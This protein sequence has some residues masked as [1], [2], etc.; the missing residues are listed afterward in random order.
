MKNLGSVIAGTMNW[1]VW[2]KKLS[3]TQMV[4][5]MKAY[6]DVGITTFDHADIYGN[7]TTEQEFGAA[8]TQSEIPRD[9]IQLITKCG[10][11]YPSEN[12]TYD[13][14]HYDYS[15]EYIRFSVETSLQ[16]LQTDYIDL[17]LL[18]RPSPL[19]RAQDIAQVIGELKKEG[20]IKAFGVS[21]FT[22][23]QMQL[24]ESHIKIDFNQ[25]EFSISQ[26]G[27]M[28]DGT[29]DYMQVNN[30]T[31]MAWSPLG[32]IFREDTPHTQRVK[33]QLTI[34]IDK[35]KVTS[36]VILLAWI[37]KHPS[38]VL[39]VVGTGDI[40]RINSVSKAQ[41]IVLDDTDWFALW[42]ASMGNKV[43]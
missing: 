39:P 17:F 26:F 32:Q 37:T 19:M 31:P 30:I 11:K 12:R 4:E 34:L 23:S 7:H 16:N 15:P 22:P 8:L 14:K 2:G 25:I 18:H 41:N 29:L 10:I 28:L 20:K 33:E 35:Y 40:N 1:G 6:I 21:N 5:M 36:D 42:E 27:A 43:P 24:I 9:S 38:G 13:L 3:T